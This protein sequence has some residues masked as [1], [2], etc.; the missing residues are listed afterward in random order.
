MHGFFS[1]AVNTTALPL[2][3]A[4]VRTITYRFLLLASKQKFRQ[5]QQVLLQ[6]ALA[7]NKATPLS[8]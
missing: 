8:A 4:T 2:A 7:T 1:A 6:A 3:A 5:A